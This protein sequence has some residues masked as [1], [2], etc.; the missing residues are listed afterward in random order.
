MYVVVYCVIILNT[1][2]TVDHGKKKK[3]NASKQ[4]FRT[5]TKSDLPLLLVNKVLLDYSQS[6]SFTYSPWLPFY[7]NGRAEQ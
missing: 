1:F 4:W 5:V 6:H 2:L 3:K 7:Y